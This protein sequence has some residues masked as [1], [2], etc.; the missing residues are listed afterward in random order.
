LVRAL[1]GLAW[2][3]HGNVPVGVAVELIKVS[4][5]LRRLEEPI[6]HAGAAEHDTGAE[7]AC[8]SDGALERADPQRHAALLREPEGADHHGVNLSRELAV[9]Q[10]KGEVLGFLRVEPTQRPPSTSSAMQRS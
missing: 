8:S 6:E 7:E 3:D 1:L 5:H 10:A 9:R 4:H 2:I